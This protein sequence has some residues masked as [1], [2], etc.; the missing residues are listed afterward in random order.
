[1]TKLKEAINNRIKLSTFAA[2][3]IPNT[4]NLLISSDIRANS[5]TKLST[6]LNLLFDLRNLTRISHWNI[7]GMN[8]KSIHTML[9]DIQSDLD[10]YIDNVAEIIVAFGGNAVI[11][12]NTTELSNI[13]ITSYCTDST[14]CF[15]KL[16]SLFS[17]V[18]KEVT[19][20]SDELD[21]NG[22]K[23]N[24]NS[25]LDLAS[26]LIKFVYLIESHLN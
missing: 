4:T 23:V 24:A 3:N 18:I 12:Y 20:I 25:L 22:D 8:F 10:G 26:K 15:T 13:D 6:L 5:V 7:K 1:M 11:E 9:D 19:N 16:A 21:V 14:K 2:T 17:Y